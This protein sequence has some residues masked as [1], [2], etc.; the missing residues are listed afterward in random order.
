MHHTYD[1]IAN[2]ELEEHQLAKFPPLPLFLYGPHEDT[3]TPHAHIILC[4][5]S[6]FL[7]SGSNVFLFWSPWLNHRPLPTTP[8]H[9][10]AHQHL[11]PKM[12]QLSM[13]DGSV[14]RCRCFVLILVSPNTTTTGSWPV[15]IVYS[16]LSYTLIYVL[17]SLFRFAVSTSIYLCWTPFF[18]SPSI[19]RSHH[20]NYTHASICNLHSLITFIFPTYTTLFTYH[21]FIV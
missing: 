2:K 15:L 8:L 3:Y 12:K 16:W 10:T 1:A 5:Y 7:C 4:F 20:C 9:F 11:L 6:L 21:S 19:C 17:S 18:F 13:D 14:S